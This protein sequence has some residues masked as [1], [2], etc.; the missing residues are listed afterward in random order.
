MFI[1]GFIKTTVYHELTHSAH[2][3]KLGNSWYSQFVGA[4]VN[5]VINTF[6]SSNKPYGDGSN[7]FDS[8]IIALGESWAYHIGEFFADREYGAASQ[9]AGEQFTNYRNGDITGLN[10]HLIALENYDPHLTG[11][12]FDWIPKGLFYDMMDTRNDINSVPR[13]V[14]INDQ[15][16]GYT[17]QQFFN[18]FSSNITD[19]TAY[20]QNLL[21]QNGNNQSPQV[22]NL[23]QQYGY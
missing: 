7:T 11:Y 21:Q 20:R 13:I 4:E 10:S 15:V 6:F 16:T 18:A 8:P 17:N 22:I 14:S 19:L 12:P 3:V 1:L 23:F 2:Y 5:E 9:P